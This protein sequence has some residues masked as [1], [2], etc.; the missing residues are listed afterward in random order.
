[1]LKL[2]W[3]AGA[4]A[5]GCMNAR[6]TKDRRLGSRVQD[7][8][9]PVTCMC[10]RVDR[11]GVQVRWRRIVLDEAHNIKDRRCAT[12]KAVFALHAKYRWAL[13]GTPLQVRCA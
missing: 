11:S 7:P 4:I 12:A 13:S 1:M 3:R 8:A 9:I 5:Q 6:H 2:L 10:L